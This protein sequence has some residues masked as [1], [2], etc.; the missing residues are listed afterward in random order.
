LR[1]SALSATPTRVVEDQKYRSTFD[2]LWVDCCALALP[3]GEKM[4]VCTASLC[5]FEFRIELDQ[6]MQIESAETL[7]DVDV[8]PGLYRIG[9]VRA[10]LLLIM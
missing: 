3:H 6:K 4:L 9:D 10:V 1:H 7:W 2:L 8:Y 5:K